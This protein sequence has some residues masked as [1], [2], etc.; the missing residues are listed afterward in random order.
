MD[1]ILDLS[2][3]LALVHRHVTLDIVHRSIHESV[4]K[5]VIL[6]DSRYG[7]KR[8]MIRLVE[9]D[10]DRGQFAPPFIITNQQWERIYEC[11]RRVFSGSKK[12]ELIK[13]IE[14]ISDVDDFYQH[15]YS[16]GLTITGWSEFSKHYRIAKRELTVITGLPSH[17]KSEF[18]DAIMVNLATQH[19]M[20]FAVF[21][22]E[23]YPYAVHVEKLLSKFNGLPFHQGPNERMTPVQ[24]SEGLQ[25]IQEHFVFI[26]PHEDEIH[27][28]AVLGLATI[29]IEEHGVHGVIIDPWNEIES[30][31][32]ATVNE[33]DYIGASLTKCRRF[34]RH[35]DVGFWIIAHP[36]KMYKDK[37][38]DIYKPPT[39][40]S[41]H[42]SA[43]WYNKS[44]N[45]LCVYREQDNKVRVL[46]QKIKFK[47]RGEIGEVLFNYNKVNGIYTE[48]NQNE[49]EF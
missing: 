30:N 45:C 25:W 39:P 33:T 11:A 20:K 23:N 14:L 21:S 46:V 41:I 43:H 27:L 7:N 29:A 36:A 32:P 8:D 19:N 35:N 13:P 16:K 28:E 44:D 10:L 22:P 9:A 15:G 37:D 47:M 2:K 42:G 48:V 4:K 24:V 5:L 17:G 1:A 26:S 38:S 34:A 49:N 12:G 31:R 3:E 18:M 40:Y 6:L